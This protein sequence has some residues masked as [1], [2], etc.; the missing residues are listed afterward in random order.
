MRIPDQED[1]ANLEILEIDR[2]LKTLMRSA[3]LGLLNEVG[4]PLTARQSV[5]GV[6]FIFRSY[7]DLFS[8]N[9]RTLLSSFANQAAIAVSNAQLVAQLQA[10]NQRKEA[11]L[12]SAPDGILILAPD[13]TIEGTNSAFTHLMGRDLKAI[14]GC[15]HD[16]V[17]QWETPPKGLTLASAEAGGWPLTPN[18][19]LYV[20]GDLKRPGLTPLPV[21]ITYS[22]LHSPEG[23]LSNIIATLRDI[24]RFRQ[25]DELKSTFISIISHELKTPVALIKGYAS[26]LNRDDA[27][28]D[29]A[30]L[31]DGLGVIEEEADRLT[32]M[33]ENLLD[34]TRLQA[35]GFNIKRAD[36]SLPDLS[37]HLAERFQTQTTHHQISVDF[38]PGFPVILADEDRLRQVLSNL[39]SNAIKYAPGGK[40]TISGG[41][42][43][44][45][46]VVC[47]SDEGPGISPD[48]LPHIFDRFYQV[49]AA[50]SR[51]NE[52][53]N[54]SE[55]KESSGTGL[56]LAIAQWIAHA[57]HGEIRVESTVGHGSAFD[58]VLPA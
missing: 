20:E 16:E 8:V 7:P 48:D 40:I 13:H 23:S 24:T 36:T 9:D 43:P 30:I 21:G 4:L 50:R 22:P 32:E 53:E 42:R 47:V 3:G 33:I 14:Q 12:D 55:G 45:Q 37:R 49:E 25:A 29:P 6:I 34:A 56:G 31:K 17:I 38:P 5:V 11:L 2:G 52:Q 18:A 39:I 57:H 46:V 1:Q 58:V 51:L 10:E 35:G 44:E 26:T 54:G 15:S 28:W 27:D 41:V 19:Q